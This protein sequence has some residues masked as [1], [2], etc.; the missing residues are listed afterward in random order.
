MMILAASASA[1]VDE[2]PPR[3]R[4]SILVDDK[5]LLD[6]HSYDGD[7]GQLN[8]VGLKP[9]KE[10]T[11]APD[12]DTQLKAT[13]RGKVV[14]RVSVVARSTP[15]PARDS[16]SKELRLV[17]DKPEDPWRLHPDDATR[18]EK[19]TDIKKTFAEVSAAEAK[20]YQT[21]AVTPTQPSAQPNAPPETNLWPWIAGSGIALL[22]VVAL[23]GVVVM[24]RKPSSPA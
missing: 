3:V 21:A 23:V 8:H 4:I 9:V 1:A 17:R 11:V 12:P 20:R 14:V 19:D 15:P 24:R 7:D 2:T 13:L 16:E 10:G 6:G 22:T 5:H 18:I